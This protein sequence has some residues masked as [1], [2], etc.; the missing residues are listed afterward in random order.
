MIGTGVTEMMMMIVEED[1]GMMTTTAEAVVEEVVMGGTVET[2][3]TATRTGEIVI[4]KTDIQQGGID[5]GTT[6][7]TTI[8]KEAVEEEEDV[9]EVTGEARKEEIAVHQPVEA[10]HRKAP[11]PSANDLDLIP[12]GTSLHQVSKEPARLPP[13]LQDC[14]VSQVRRD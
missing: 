8:A 10:Q 14:S 6:K 4:V 11:S 2:A 13:R 5:H 9:V 7:T 12:S 1:V 3:E